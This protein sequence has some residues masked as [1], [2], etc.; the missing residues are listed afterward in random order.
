MINSN[1]YLEKLKEILELQ[2]QI[3]NIVKI[4]NTVSS[5]YF[6]NKEKLIAKLSILNYD[7]NN[8][9]IVQL[10]QK[11]IKIE[12]EILK[13]ANKMLN[14]SKLKISQHEKSTQNMV[15]YFKSQ[16]ELQSEID[17]KA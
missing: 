13:E 12:E 2:N 14:I 10:R 17:F 6:E 7:K 1:L 3:L 16:I 11:I 9:D 4:G 15:N 5:D 8:Q